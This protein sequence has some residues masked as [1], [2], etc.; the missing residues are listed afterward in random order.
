MQPTTSQN[1]LH[2]DCLANL[3]RVLELAMQTAETASAESDHK[4]VLQAI[5]GVIRIITLMLKMADTSDREIGS[6][7]MAF[8]PR[9]GLDRALDPQP[10]MTGAGGVG[11]LL[12]NSSPKKPTENQKPKTANPLLNKWEKSG[13]LPGKKSLFLEVINQENQEDMLFDKNPEKNPTSWSP[14]APPVSEETSRCASCLSAASP[15]E[16]ENRKST[17]DNCFFKQ[18]KTSEKLPK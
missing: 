10:A 17:N 12:V 9:T 11:S 15:S 3:N 14:S 6:P 4:V 5:N 2:Q 16:T 7:R 1:N 18:G 13:K 8:I